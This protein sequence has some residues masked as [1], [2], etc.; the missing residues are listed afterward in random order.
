METCLTMDSPLG[1]LCL[2]EEEGRLTRLTFVNAPVQGEEPP[3]DILLEAKKQLEEYFSGNRTAFSLPMKPKG[4]L[5]CQAV[6]DTLLSIPYGE[7]CSYSDLAGKMNHPRAARAV[8]QANARNPLP[9]LIP[10][11]RVI[12]FDGSL[13]GY[14]GGKEIKQKL[15]A[16]EGCNLSKT[17]L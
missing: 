14:T 11:H 1:I 12:A 13:G 5:F 6:W 7:T 15:L 10:C 9:I 2:C 3:A 16:L 8:G 4:T 17:A